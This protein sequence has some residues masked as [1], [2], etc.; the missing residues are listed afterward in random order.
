MKIPLESGNWRVRAATDQVVLSVNFLPDGKHLVSGGFEGTLRRWQVRDDREVGIPIET[1]S[2]IHGTGTSKDGN[3]IVSGNKGW[4]VVANAKTDEKVIAHSELHGF[5]WVR[6]VDVSPDST[7]FATASDDCTS[8]IWCLSTGRRLVG[9]MMHETMVV[10]VKFSPRGD[11]VATATMSSINPVRIFD[12]RNGQLLHTLPITMPIRNE[13]C[14]PLT[15][16]KHGQL[17]VG[18]GGK[19]FCFDGFTNSFKLLSEGMAHSE[20]NHTSVFLSSTGKFLACSTDRLISF[21]DTSWKRLEPVIEDPTNVHCIAISPDNMFLAS[22]GD[23]KIILRSLRDILPRYYTSDTPLLRISED[24]FKPWMQQDW[25]NA[26]IVLTEEIT[27]SSSSNRWDALAN[28]AL[29]RARLQRWREAYDD[30]E[31]SLTI[32]LTVVG[33]IAK[34][35]SL[36]GKGKKEAATRR[37]DLVFCDCDPEEC[38]SEFLLLIKAIL[39]F[40]AGKRDEAILRVQDLISRVDNDVAY[41]Y[42]M[43]LMTMKQ[44]DYGRTL[45]PLELPDNL[46]QSNS[47]AYLTTISLVSCSLSFPFMYIDP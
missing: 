24:L 18:S 42:P 26:E 38:E 17:F 32:Q 43:D 13:H 10:A 25:T 2:V 8:C 37:I 20:V 30:A 5:S 39:L 44:L 41:C 12:S 27:S 23:Q 14:T 31:E 46:A 9:P 19:I 28:R 11:R 47:I 36:V 15:W 45:E 34:A 40:E 16:S 29:I 7:R 1:G 21:W 35:I 33:H 6:A 22:G 4:I 3:W